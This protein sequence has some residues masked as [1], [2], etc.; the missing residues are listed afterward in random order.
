VDRWTKVSPKIQATRSISVAMLE[1]SIRSNGYDDAVDG[2]GRG[3]V[4]TMKVD[5]CNC[6]SDREHGYVCDRECRKNQRLEWKTE[7]ID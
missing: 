2:N 7:R 5:C 4:N 1:R 6:G 3:D